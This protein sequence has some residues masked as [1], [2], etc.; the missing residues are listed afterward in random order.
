MA[1]EK[2]PLSGVSGAGIAAFGTAAFQDA[3][4][5]E[6][7]MGRWSRRLAPAL[8]RFGG[9]SDGDRVLDVGCG[10]GSLILALQDFANIVAATGIDLVEPYIDAARTRNADPR[11]TFDLGDA[12]ALPYPDASFDRA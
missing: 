8:I 3:D 1:E 12:R 5:Y 6:Q 7:L 11:L 4:R 2:T 10:T 9:L